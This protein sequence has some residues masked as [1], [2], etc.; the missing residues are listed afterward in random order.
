ME[1]R[2]AQLLKKDTIGVTFEHLGLSMLLI[3]EAHEYKNLGLP[4]NVEGFQVEASK[5]ATD[6]EMKLRWLEQRGTGPF[7]AFFTATPLSNNMVEAYVL[8]WYL[9]QQR[10]LQYGLNSVDAFVANF[11]DITTEV[12]ISPDGSTFRMKNRPRAFFNYDDF[13]DMF[14]QFADI[15]TSDILDDKRPRREDITIAEDASS[16]ML[17]CVDSLVKRADKLRAGGHPMH[18]GKE[19]NMLR[20]VHEGREL[21]VS[22][23]QVGILTGP[24]PKVETVA[25]RMIEV[26]QRWQ[27]HPV[28]LAGEFNSLQIGFCDLGTPSSEKGDQ[29]Y[30]ELK[31]ALVAG[32]IPEYGIRYIHE[33]NND[34]AKAALFEQCRQG[35]VAILLGSTAKLG[36]GT[37]VQYRCA[38]I[39]IIAP[40][41]RP[42]DVEQCI[43]R[44]HR[45]GNRFSGVQIYRY[46]VRKTFD[47]YMWQTLERK[48]HFMTQFMSGKVKGREIDTQGEME[49][50]FA[51]VKAAATGDPLLLE[52]AATGMELARLQSL[53]KSFY[54]AR[55]RDKW[56]A[57][58]AR[59]AAERTRQS[60]HFFQQFAEEVQQ[61]RYPGFRSL[62]GE[63]LE[64]HPKIGKLITERVFAFAMQGVCSWQPIA[65]WSDRDLFLAVEGDITSLKVAIAVGNRS[66][67]RMRV[68]VN[69]IW[70]GDG[71]QWRIA[72]AIADFFAKAATNHEH[73]LAEAE[74]KD[75][76]ALQFEAEAQKTFAQEIR[77]KKLMGRKMALD[78]YTTAVAGNKSEEEIAALKAELL[79]GAEKDY[80]LDLEKAITPV[81]PMQIVLLPE[82]EQVE[83]QGEQEVQAELTAPP[84]VEAVTE[85]ITPVTE[86][87]PVIAISPTAPIK[88][89]WVVVIDPRCLATPQPTVIQPEL[90]LNAEPVL[91]VQVAP[92]SVEKQLQLLPNPEQ[93]TPATPTRKKPTT[94]TT[95]QIPEVKSVQKTRPSIVKRFV[96]PIVVATLTTVSLFGD[97]LP[98]RSDEGTRRKYG[99][100]RKK[101]TV[102]MGMQPCLPGLECATGTNEE[103]KSRKKKGRDQQAEYP[104]MSGVTISD[105]VLKF[106]QVPPKIAKRSKSSSKLQPAGTKQKKEATS[107]MP[108]LAVALTL[109]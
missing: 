34:A 53:A 40:P 27:N 7:A 20:V 39:H 81:Q 99:P 94:R 104:A 8:A 96:E 51:E 43:G 62:A 100:R 5:R 29:V 107:K 19:D 9:D 68:E 31:R 90:V 52:Q 97:L 109:F 50:N 10:L 86:T 15:Q 72:K 37:N 48:A 21:A 85:V 61:C 38:A 44:G 16:E 6:L 47:A 87:A 45:P 83:E 12:E 64:D 102:S 88:N 65:R 79:A 28:K 95:L 3:D 35:E 49:L 74:G 101:A 76:E 106:G 23:R 93:A 11:I 80:A 54:G 59:S 24:S 105:L 98:I 1:E 25:T 4:S 66:D 14:A 2:Q 33:A 26:Y 84:M 55:E 57:R 70:T 91:P 69:P 82:V 22:P 77:L 41:W 18:G 36:T 30:G 60:A 103:P 58:T 89:N 32:G 108:Q 46:V 42:A 56:E 17:A 78:Q 63:T 73:L 13:Q 67:E 71:N 92:T 75:R